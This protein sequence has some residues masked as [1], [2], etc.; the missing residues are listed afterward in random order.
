MTAKSKAKNMVQGKLNFGV[1]KKAGL[2]VLAGHGL[3]YVNVGPISAVA[4]ICCATFT[5]N[6]ESTALCAD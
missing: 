1:A 3:T 5:T 6:G 2:G 4:G